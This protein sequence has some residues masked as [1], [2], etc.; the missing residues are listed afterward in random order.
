MVEMDSNMQKF[1]EERR[2]SI[3]DISKAVK[4]DSST[5][6]A[7]DRAKRQRQLAIDKRVS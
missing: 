7:A 6:S 1:L 4:A 5:E 3:G 2:I